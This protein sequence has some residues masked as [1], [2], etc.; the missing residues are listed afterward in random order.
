MSGISSKALNGAPENKKKY[1]GYEYNTDFDLNLYESFYRTHDPQIGR[2]WQPDPRPTES[3]SLYAAMENNPIKYTDALGD[4]T[5]FY[6]YQGNRIFAVNDKG[7]NRTVV[8]DEKK[9]EGF[10]NSYYENFALVPDS[11]RDLTAMSSSLSAFGTS[12][13]VASFE[14]FYDANAKSVPATNVDGNP[15]AGMSNIQINGKPTKLNAEVMG[16]LVMKDGVV[17]VGQGKSSTG[18]LV[19]SDPN[20]LPQEQGKVGHIHT[21][22]VA[23]DASLSY[24]RGGVTSGGSFRAGPSPADRQEADKNKGGIRN[25]VVDQKN[26]YLING[27]SNQTVIIPR[28]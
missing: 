9:E 28:R 17:T 10:Y 2:F 13:D 8:L 18:D 20:K 26:V 4:T 5:I 1:Q 15:T 6:G 27:W 16:N 7:S 21:H 12:Y 14:G 24:T 11:K 22:P 25:V 23:T 19:S 3:T